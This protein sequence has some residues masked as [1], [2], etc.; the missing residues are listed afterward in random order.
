MNVMQLNCQRAYVVTCDVGVI[1]YE[2][3]VSVALL[4]ELYVN[5]GCV[6]GLPSAWRVFSCL[7][8]PGRAAVVVKDEGIEP[9]C[10]DEY[11]SELAVCV[12]LKGDFGELI[13][14][15]MYCRYG[16][17]I[18]PYLAYMDRVNE[19]ARGKY[20]LF[21]MDANAASPLWYSKAGGHG[22]ENEMRG[23]VLEEWVLMNGMIV[24]NEP[25]ECYTFSG[26]NGMSDIDVTLM[27]WMPAGCR[28]EWEVKCDWGISDHN[29][30]LI[31]IL[32][33]VNEREC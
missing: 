14:V 23:R 4:Q 7:E 5:E 3:G 19:F 18:E 11:T 17:D 30:V 24:L 10:V 16:R 32:Y 13:V 31:R 12:W 22:R 28:F 25:S 27:S 15:S 20:V 26:V 33:G 8:E 21:G 29:V 6:K 9:V 1:M 2:K